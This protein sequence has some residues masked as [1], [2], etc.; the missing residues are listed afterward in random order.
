[1]ITTILIDDEPIGLKHLASLI[2]KYAP[3][4]EIKATV[5]SVDEA[6]DAL[7]VIKPDLV[8][9]DIELSGENSFEIL[10]QTKVLQYEKIFV[11][12][13]AEFGIQA[14]KQN[15][16]GYILKPIDKIDLIEAIEKA[17]TKIYQQ[18]QY[19]NQSQVSETHQNP[20]N[21]RLGLPTLEGLVFVD[22]NKILYCEAEGRYTRFHLADNNKKILV[23]KNIGEYEILLAEKAFVR[24]HNHYLVNIN[25]VEQYIKGRGGNVI[26][27]NGNSLEVSSRKRD[28]FLERLEK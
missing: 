10:K 25:Y 23:S 5:S 28:S 11:T 26:M 13:H 7:F 21:T 2:A 18:R 27:T 9:L 1:M 8:F 14:I 4:L 15:A 3:N 12:A 17:S 19:H 24:I 20:T 6:V 16:I 22:T